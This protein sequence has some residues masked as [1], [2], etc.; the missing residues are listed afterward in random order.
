[1]GFCSG[2]RRLVKFPGRFSPQIARL[3][4]PSRA[5]LVYRGVGT[6]QRAEQ[7]EASGLAILGPM[8]GWRT[9]LA[10]SRE[11]SMAKASLLIASLPLVPVTA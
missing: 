8:A 3:C 7:F 5:R 1:M 6:P 4:A 2:Y 10:Y 11:T 9:L